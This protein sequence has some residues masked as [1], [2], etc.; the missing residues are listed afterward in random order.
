MAEGRTAAIFGATGLVGRLCLDL[1]LADQRYVRVVAIGRRE[2]AQSG[3]KLVVRRAALDTAEALDDPTLGTVDDVFCCLGTTLKKAGS[4]EA[5]RRVDRR[6]RRQLR[7]AARRAPLPHGV[8]DGGRC[9]LARVLQSRQRRGRGRG[10]EARRRMCLD[11]PAVL[12]SRATRGVP[13][14]GA[15]WDGGGNCSLVRPGRSAGEISPDRGR[16][17]CAGHACRGRHAGSGRYDV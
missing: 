4:Q 13:F 7:Q 17:D 1:L 11:L 2:P 6:E 3:P 12:H 8:S 5:F 10:C 14:G 9:A 16:D 15:A